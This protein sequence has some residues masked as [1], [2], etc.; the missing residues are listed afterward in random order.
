MIWLLL[1][2]FATLGL[3]LKVALVVVRKV[4]RVSYDDREDLLEVLRER[5]NYRNLYQ[6]TTAVEAHRGPEWWKCLGGGTAYHHL[7]ALV[8]E[9]LVKKR[10]L[11]PGP[12]TYWR[13]AD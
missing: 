8:E 7:E 10:V 13:I 3:F 2:V 1:P 12:R 4:K 11:E 9:G 5:P 6:L